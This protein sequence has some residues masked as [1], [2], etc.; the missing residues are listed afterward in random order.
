MSIEVMPERLTREDLA[1]LTTAVKLLEGRS[2]AS[3]LT[4]PVR[5]PDRDHEQRAAGIGA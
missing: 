5:P 1:D 3:R 4:E 2:L